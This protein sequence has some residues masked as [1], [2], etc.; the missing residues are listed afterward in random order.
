MGNEEWI[1]HCTS[2]NRDA[3]LTDYRVELMHKQISELF[4]RLPDNLDD[5]SF[6][7]QAVQPEA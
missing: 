5:F 7:S 3:K 6:A 4:D 2:S 1:L